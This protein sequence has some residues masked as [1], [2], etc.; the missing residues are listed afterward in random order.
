MDLER[1]ESVTNRATMSILNNNMKNYN[2]KCLEVRNQTKN[3][4]QYQSFIVSS[5]KEKVH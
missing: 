5:G 3:S 4:L 2:A 1:A